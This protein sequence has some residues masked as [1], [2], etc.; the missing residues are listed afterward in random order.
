MLVG[1]SVGYIAFDPVL[2]CIT[3]TPVQLLKKLPTIID[4][5]FCLTDYQRW[6]ETK[7]CLTNLSEKEEA[8]TSWTE[9]T[10]N[11]WPELVMEKVGHQAKWPPLGKWTFSEAFFWQKYLYLDSDFNQVCCEGSVMCILLHATEHNQ[12]TWLTFCIPHF[13]KYFLAR[14]QKSV[15]GLGSIPFLAATKQL[16]DW[17]SPSVHPVMGLGAH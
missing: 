10:S 9:V 12:T 13:V 16:Y 7:V 1:F 8:V 17:F 3:I 15:A 5:Y 2:V 4:E 11:Q 6:N 14:K